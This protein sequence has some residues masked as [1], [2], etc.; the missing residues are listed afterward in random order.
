[1]LSSIG[2]TR[3]MCFFM[4]LLSAKVKTHEGMGA[5]MSPTEKEY[6]C[7][8]CGTRL[9]DKGTVVFACPACEKGT[10]GRCAQCRDQSV[11]FTCQECGYEGP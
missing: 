8:S 11:P 10:I 9:V 5:G 3:G 6:S 2:F 4:H 1:M 7:T